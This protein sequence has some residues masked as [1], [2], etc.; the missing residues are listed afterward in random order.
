[1]KPATSST[2][3]TPA[4]VMTFYLSERSDYSLAK[5]VHCLIEAIPMGEGALQLRVTSNTKC[6]EKFVLESTHLRGQFFNTMKT[7]YFEDKLSKG[8]S[9]E[10]V[11]NTKK[12][13]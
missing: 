5:T 3:Q 12:M 4:K 11:I 6:V 7:S 10:L 13:Q 8:C 1:M 2:Y 9:I